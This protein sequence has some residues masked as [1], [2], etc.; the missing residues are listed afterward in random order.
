MPVHSREMKTAPTLEMLSLW[1]PIGL[2][3]I[4]EISLAGPRNLG[5][6]HKRLQELKQ[7]K[8]C[9]FGG[10]HTIFIGDLY[11]LQSMGGSLFQLSSGN[12][13]AEAVDGYNI[14]MTSM[15]SAVELVTNH[16]Q[17]EDERP[18]HAALERFRTNEP[19]I[20]DIELI[21]SR[22]VTPFTN[23][24]PH[25]TPMVVPYNSDRFDLIT[26]SFHAYLRANP[27]VMDSVTLRPLQ[28]WRERGALRIRARITTKD[29]RFVDPKQLQ[30]LADCVV[31]LPPPLKA[32]ESGQKTHLSGELN[33]VLGGLY[34][35]TTNVQVAS[36]M[37][38]GT[39]CR[40]VDVLVYRELDINIDYSD[41]TLF[42]GGLHTTSIDNVQGLVFRHEQQFWKEQNRFKHL[43][44]GCFPVVSSF[45]V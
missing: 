40:L 8:G 42:S 13:S 38:N 10:I 23:R 6:I 30:Q 15:N 19:T 21:N 39:M 20:D 45:V 25:G 26:N 11:Q 2:L 35:L 31:K 27:L 24:P 3:I 29:S 1:L 32:D 5:L 36:G 22:V 17:S 43:P 44:T 37:A 41:I 28:T 12:R 16:R 33:L 9:L 7:Q 18:F 14:W 34:M 4:D